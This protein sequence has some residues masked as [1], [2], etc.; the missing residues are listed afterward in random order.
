MAELPVGREARGKAGVFGSSINPLSVYMQYSAQRQRNRAAMEAQQRAERDKAMDYL[1]KFNPSSKFEIFNRDVNDQAKGVR[2]WYIQQKELGR[3]DLEIMPELKHKQGQ[4]LSY[5]EEA[6]GWKKII[7]DLE[8]KV[9]NDPIRYK[10]EGPDTL[11]SLLRNIYLNADGSKKQDINEIREGFNNADRLLYDPRVINEDGAIKLWTEKLPE[12]SRVLLTKAYSAMGY[13]PDQIENI[14]KSGLTYEMEPDPQ[15]GEMRPK[16]DDDLLPKVI[17]DEKLYRLAKADPWVNSLMM[18][19]SASKDGQM[20][21]LRK[22]VRGQGDKVIFDR[23]VISGKK[24]DDFRYSYGGGRYR[25]PIADL[26]ER[27]KILTQISL[28]GPTGESLLGYFDDPM[29]EVKA[30]YANEAKIDGKTKKG[31]FVKVDYTTSTIDLPKV[32]DEE[33]N[34]MTFAERKRY[35][36]GMKNRKV[37]KSNYYDITTEDGRDKLKIA[38]SAEMDRMNKTKAI[39]EEYPR[40][41]NDS[42]TMKNK[43]KGKKGAYNFD[44]AGQ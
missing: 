31:Q 12:Q 8:T 17:V 28:G 20:D 27:D 30:S 24:N 5:A 4:V 2:E 37:V 21:W 22:K 15:T 13:S 18:A 40:F 25:T 39:A 14:V 6:D 43:S 19:A 9:N 44:N 23:Q 35:D 26:Q 29:S 7:D 3:G 41:I 10:V 42:R 33:Y 38:L 34:N 11:K 1:D 16:L 32:S 36:E